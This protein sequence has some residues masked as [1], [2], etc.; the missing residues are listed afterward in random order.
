VDMKRVLEKV[1]Y[2]AA[3]LVGIGIL[4]TGFLAYFVISFDPATRH[5]FDGL[6]RELEPSPWFIRWI[7]GQDRDW[8]GWGWWLFDFVWFWGGIA[9]AYGLVKL[10]ERFKQR[11]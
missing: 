10:G 2:A 8:P 4:V 9:I 3:G 1:C 6:G 7:F 5:H 11:A